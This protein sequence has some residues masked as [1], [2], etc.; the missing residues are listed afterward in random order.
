[1]RQLT[2]VVSFITGDAI[3]TA[4]MT[5]ARAL[6]EVGKVDVVSVPTID[7]EGVAGYTDMLLLPTGGLVSA[8]FPTDFAE[9][10]NEPLLADLAARAQNLVVARFVGKPLAYE[11]PDVWEHPGV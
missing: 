9:V 3:A 8:P 6:A 11:D 7:R 4:L 2:N 1:M 5:Y 10:E